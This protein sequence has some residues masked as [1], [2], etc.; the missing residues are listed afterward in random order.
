MPNFTT[1]TDFL[2]ARFSDVWKFRVLHSALFLLTYLATLMGNLLIVTVTTLDQSLHTPMYFF[3]RILSIVDM[4][5]ISITVPKACIIFLFDSRVISIVGC[6]TQIFLIL[7][8]AFVELMLLTIMARDRYVAICHPLHYPV[9]MNPQVCV[10]MSL[11]SLLSGF[12][13]AGFHTGLTFCLPFCQSNIIHQFFCDMPSLLKLSCSD[14]FINEIIIFVSS[15]MLAGGCFSLII[16]SYI[17]ILSTVLKFPI[18]GERRKAFSTCVPHILVVTVFLSSGAAVYMKPTSNSPKIQDMI[19]S[20][21]YTV[22]PPFLNPMIYS[23]R[24]KQIK[25][26]VWRIINT[27]LYSG[28]L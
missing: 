8:F 3:L 20:V 12:V 11:A 23:L 16:L 9:I 1:V 21:F 25:M 10:Q 28:K 2:L 19:V 14:T 4:G 22:V 5:Y 17:R 24:N 26:A 6:A 18:R 7:L 27:M 15:V 13:Y